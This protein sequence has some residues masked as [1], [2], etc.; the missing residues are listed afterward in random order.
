MTDE[1]RFNVNDAVVKITWLALSIT[2]VVLLEFAGRYNWID[3]LTWAPPSEILGRVAENVRSGAYWSRFLFSV[4]AI[5]ISFFLSTAVGLL[6]GIALSF[7]ARIYR[8]LEPYLESYYALP[9]FVFYPVALSLLGLGIWSLVAIAGVWSVGAMVVN[10]VIGISRVPNVLIRYAQSL[11]LSRLK[12][13]LRVVLPYALPSILTGIKLALVYSISGVIGSEF[14]LSSRGIGRL[15]AN[16]YNSFATADMYATMV[17]VIVIILS[18]YGAVAKW[19]RRVRSR[20][21]I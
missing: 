8:L 4:T 6:A 7:N 19:E 9:L 15:V 13:L 18:L 11:N 16:S 3:P 2:A 12:T 20:R 17:L 21:G 1:G 5:A 14:I 10:T